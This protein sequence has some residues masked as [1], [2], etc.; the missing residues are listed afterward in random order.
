RHSLTLKSEGG[1]IEASP[2]EADYAH[3][4][5]VALKALPLEGYHF[6]G[7][8][9]DL[10][11]SELKA[12][13]VMDSPKNV[14]ALFETTRYALTVTAEHGK[15]LLDPEA[16][17][18]AHGTRVRLKAEPSE[19]YIFLNW[20]G[21][22]SGSKPKETLEM[23]SAKE[24]RAVFA[25]I[26]K[27]A[28][29]IPVPHV[30]SEPIV[31]VPPVSPAIEPV[32]PQA[33]PVVRPEPP[34]AVPVVRPEHIA[35]VVELEQTA[36]VVELEHIA[37][38]VELEQTAPVVEPLQVVP[39]VEP[40]APLEL[41]SPVAV[42]PESTEEEN[43]LRTAAVE[44]L[45]ERGVE[46]SENVLLEKAKAGDAETVRLLLEAGMDPNT[47]GK[48]G[49]TLLMTAVIEGHVEAARVL[50][51]EGADLNV[52]DSSGLT[53]LMWAVVTSDESP[54]TDVMKLLIDAGADIN[55]AT[56]SGMTA[57]RYTRGLPHAEVAQ[58]LREGGAR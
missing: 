34:Q 22:L 25:E 15:V 43:K 56:K 19:G 49:T 57:L 5:R 3:G 37:P 20:E 47:E 24:V 40:P 28:P 6:T 36:P 30:P 4:T 2:Q 39:L 12:A 35:P 46:V 55:A 41:I 31:E 27:P 23:N 42:A 14:T 38:V 18:Y 33:V 48:F 10:S 1:R 54:K 52:R 58:L 44:K 45:K 53:A 8:Q 29:P 51:E 9:G 7:W 26:P 11:G 17:E 50:I 21:A 16:A 32:P 13:L